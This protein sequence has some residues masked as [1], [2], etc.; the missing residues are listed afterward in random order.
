MKIS[1]CSKSALRRGK[2]F[3]FFF[4]RGIRNKKL[5]KVKNFRNWFTEYFF[6]KGQKPQGGAYSAPIHPHGL[7]GEKKYGLSDV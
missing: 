4:H 3:G 1:G 5:G 2:I 7:K 6:S